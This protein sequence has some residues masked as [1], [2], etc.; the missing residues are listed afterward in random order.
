MSC[1]GLVSCGSTARAD[2][3]S[4]ATKKRWSRSTVYG[5]NWRRRRKPPSAKLTLL[6]PPPHG[7]IQRHLFLLIGLDRAF[8]LALST[9]TQALLATPSR[10]LSGEPATIWQP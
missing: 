10:A 6:S 8:S 3:H 2:R 5:S 9:S 4:I 7:P 1:Q